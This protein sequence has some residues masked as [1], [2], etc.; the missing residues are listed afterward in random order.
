MFV[1]PGFQRGSLLLSAWRNVATFSAGGD[2]RLEWIA[3]RPDMIVTVTFLLFARKAG[4][5]SLVSKRIS[6][7]PKTKLLL[8][9][10]LARYVRRKNESV[11]L[12]TLTLTPTLMEGALG[13]R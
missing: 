2:T 6:F 1:R 13:V 10:F 9:A 12:E 5:R 4:N 7:H 11:A 3:R 8:S